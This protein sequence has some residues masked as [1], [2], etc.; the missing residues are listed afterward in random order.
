MAATTRLIGN[1]NQNNTSN[2][3][4]K[5]RTAETTDYDTFIKLLI[6]QMKYQDPTQPVDATQYVSQ[7]ASFSA[8]EQTL[9]IN[10]KIDEILVNAPIMLATSYIGKYV[11]S[12]DG[13]ISGIVKSVKIY[14]DGVVA[15]LDNGEE[16]VIGPGVIVSDKAPAKEPKE[17]AA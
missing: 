6:A 13:K 17:E 1:Y 10:K 11:E 9:Q 16:L 7:L 5:N 14:S 8:V 3:L 4:D 2:T 12:E 15:T